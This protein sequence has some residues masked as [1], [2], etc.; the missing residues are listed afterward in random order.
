MKDKNRVLGLDSKPLKRELCNKSIYA[1]ASIH[2]C[3]H[4]CVYIYIYMYM[5][6]CIHRF[7]YV[8][9]YIYRYVH[10][11]TYYTHACIVC[12]S[13]ALVSSSGFFHCDS[14]IL[15]IRVLLNAWR[16]HIYIYDSVYCV[17]G[18][19]QNKGYRFLG[20]LQQK[21][22]AVWSLYWVHLFNEAAIYI[23]YIGWLSKLWALFGSLV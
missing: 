23:Y 20:F 17:R 21:V 8:Y 5:R 13:L 3:V 1:C 11:Y 9:I 18:V 15:L 6:V 14:T 2:M 19:S 10:T 12:L 4:L 16:V 22:T 7:V